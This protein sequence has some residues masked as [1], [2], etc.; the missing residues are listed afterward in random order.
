MA[1]SVERQSLSC[2]EAASQAAM[3]EP[4]TSASLSRKSC[5]NDPRFVLSEGKICAKVGSQ[6]QDAIQISGLRD[7]RRHKVRQSRLCPSPETEVTKLQALAMKESNEDGQ[8]DTNSILMAC[9][10]LHPADPIYL[11]LSL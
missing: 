10:S 9:K 4:R 5:V 11:L 8:I 6:S 2:V 3:S 1:A 7:V